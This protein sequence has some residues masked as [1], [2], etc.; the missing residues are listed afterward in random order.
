MWEADGWTCAVKRTAFKSAVMQLTCR[1]LLAEDGWSS[2][3]SQ[4]RLHQPQPE[5]QH[6]L[7]P[8]A[9]TYQPCSKQQQVHCAY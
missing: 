8:G 5:T 2:D 6:F 7:G 4:R 3:I 9:S 1:P